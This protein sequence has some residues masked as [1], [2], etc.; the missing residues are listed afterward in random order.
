MP[1]P[2]GTGIPGPLTS[3]AGSTSTSPKPDTNSNGRKPNTKSKGPKSHQASRL[4]ASTSS[5]S[6]STPAFPPSTGTPGA[7]TSAADSIPA[8]PKPNTKSKGRKSRRASRLAASTS[9]VS[10]SAPASPAAHLVARGNAVQSVNPSPRHKVPSPFVFDKWDEDTVENV[11][12]VALD[13]CPCPIFSHGT[14]TE[15]T[16]RPCS[17]GETRVVKVFGAGNVVRDTRY[18]SEG[19]S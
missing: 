3:A 10:Q 8:S 18:L 4:A 1:P 13:V 9:S 2:S 15:S 6:Q 16:E 11:L 14:H 12:G 7:S 5:V 17:E 19:Q